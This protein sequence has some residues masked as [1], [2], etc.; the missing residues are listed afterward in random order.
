MRKMIDILAWI[1]RLIGKP[2]GWERVVRLLAPT[3]RCRGLDDI[4][5][6]RDGVMFLAQPSVPLGWNVVL[7]GTYEP[8]LREII[9]KVL[10]AGGTALD[11]GANVG[12]H[13]LLMAR[14]AGA[15][16]RVLAAEAN[17]SVRRLLEAN[18]K[19]NGFHQVDIISCAVAER[20]GKAEF[21]GP[22]AEAAGSGDGHMVPAGGQRQGVI[23]VET[24]SVDAIC[25]ESRV[26]RLDLIKI[27][28]EGFEWPVLQ[29]AEKSIAKFRPHIV[30]EFNEEY[31]AR[32]GGDAK[33]LSA[34]LMKHRYRPFAIRRS[35]ADPVVPNAWPSCSDIWAVPD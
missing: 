34:F 25:D 26:E 33:L 11:V 5:V 32:G 22:D 4:C 1:G 35:W 16:G 10:P 3:E 6:T 13:T 9:R 24:R 18:L 8:F 21:W 29:G 28:V 15:N 23:P 19:L 12:W 31:A 27:D 7:F 14:T 2:P 20:E 17:P 30:F